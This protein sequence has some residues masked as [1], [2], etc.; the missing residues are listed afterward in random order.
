[1]KINTVLTDIFF[2]IYM[3]ILLENRVPGMFSSCPN[4]FSNEQQDKLWLEKCRSVSP[5]SAFQMRLEYSSRQVK[6]FA[7]V[8]LGHFNDQEFVRVT[9]RA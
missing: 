3:H 5:V 2:F 8:F 4:V 9:L 7:C 6:A 1:M